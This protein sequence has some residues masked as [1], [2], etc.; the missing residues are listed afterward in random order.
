MLKPAPQPNLHWNDHH[1]CHMPSFIHTYQNV[2]SFAALLHG[3]ADMIDEDF[4]S[5][6]LQIEILLC[7]NMMYSVA[8]Y[9]GALY[10]HAD[11]FTFSHLSSHSPTPKV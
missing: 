11:F 2:S 3:Q 8:A 6:Q 7:L 9:A 5:V 1:F 10:N 4:L